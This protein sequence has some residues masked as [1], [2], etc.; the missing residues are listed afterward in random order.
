MQGKLLEKNA[1]LQSGQ[2]KYEMNL[3]ISTAW[4]RATELIVTCCL[5]L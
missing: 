2:V 5:G 4:P 3:G 1:I